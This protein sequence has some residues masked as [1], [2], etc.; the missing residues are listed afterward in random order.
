MGVL[1]ALYLWRDGVGRDSDKPPGRVVNN[2]QLLALARQVPL[3]FQQLKRSG[4]KS[5]VLSAHG[6]ALLEAIKQGR[7]KGDD[8]LP[9]PRHREVDESEEKR[10]DRLK[11]WRRSEAEKRNVPL[12]VV[13]PARALD[14]LKR[15]GAV[16]LTTV[17]QLGAKRSERYGAKLLD[18]CR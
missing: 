6:D 12:Q 7:E 18:L 10:E 3:S 4:V 16:D 2:E 13:L 14:H 15:H 17:P 5:W 8:V 1:A 9:A 11:D